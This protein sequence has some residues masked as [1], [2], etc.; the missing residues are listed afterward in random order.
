M[1][2]QGV[3]HEIET[4]SNPPFRPI[5]NLSTC[6]LSALREYLD[7]ALEKGW[8]QHSTSLAGAP[9]LFVPKKDGGLRLYVNYRALNKV[10]RK[11]RLALL[12]ISEIL[13]QL[14]GATHLLKVDL[15][16]AYYYILVAER[17]C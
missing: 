2:V 9:I 15:K 12:L 17:D 8:I 14:K 6:K 1:L 4:F 3:E 13:D 10:T 5:Y 16:D 11:N 7:T